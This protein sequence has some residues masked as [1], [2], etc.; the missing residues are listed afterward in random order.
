MARTPNQRAVAGALRNGF[1]SETGSEGAIIINSLLALP[2]EGAR[3]ALDLLSGE[4]HA[5]IA[6]VLFGQSRQLTNL[7]AE[8]LWG[9]GPTAGATLASQQTGMMGL[10]LAPGQTHELMSLGG[11]A[12]EGTE[13]RP[14]RLATWVRG[15]G[16]IG[17]INGDGNAERLESRTGG[18]MAGGDAPVAPGIVVGAMG[19]WGSSEADV[20][21]RASTA[22][23]ESG[24]VAV[25]ASAASGDLLLKGVA[26]YSHH[27]IDVTRHIAFAAISR[28]A[29]SSYGADQASLYGEAGWRWRLAAAWA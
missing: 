14:S 8:R 21:Q 7:A 15:Y 11:A 17:S 5:S 22:K 27:D 29:N 12:R 1:R 13:P 16:D 20:D 26:G 9:A 23:I 4:I 24:H 6:H 18:L 28:T 2:P 19:G 3:F 25:Y 10:G